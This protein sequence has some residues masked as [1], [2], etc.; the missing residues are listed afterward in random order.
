[1]NVLMIVMVVV[2]QA[3]ETEVIAEEPQ[4]KQQDAG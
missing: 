3:V 2:L 4:R 1:M